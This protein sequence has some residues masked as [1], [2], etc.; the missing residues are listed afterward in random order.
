LETAGTPRTNVA[1][2]WTFKT[3]SYTL[4]QFDPAAFPPL[5]PT[6][7]DLAINP[8]TKLVNA[9]V[10]PLS[11]PAQQEFTTDYLNTLNGFPVSATG[12]AIVQGGNL[13]PASIV[14]V[15]TPTDGGVP[16]D[17]VFVVDLT[18]GNPV[19]GVAVSYDASSHALSLAPPMAPGQ[20]QE[21]ALV[22]VG[23]RMACAIRTAA[24]S[25][26]APPGPWPAGSVAGHL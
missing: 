19:D 26:P 11:S 3:T 21:L 20:V 8:V 2:L 5:V 25:S 13:D 24:W 18:T 4:M 9:P 22:V 6:P 23:A 1:L 15:G 12:T 16:N 17:N 10:D 7:N 14:A